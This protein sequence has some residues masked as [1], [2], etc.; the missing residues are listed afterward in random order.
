[1]YPDQAHLFDRGRKYSRHHLRREHMP[2][3]KV[4]FALLRLRWVGSARVWLV[5]MAG[6]VFAL[7]WCASSLGFKGYHA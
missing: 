1:M 2:L 7:D 4:C 5:Q 6:Y 3:F